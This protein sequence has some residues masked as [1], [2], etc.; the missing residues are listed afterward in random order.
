MSQYADACIVIGRFCNKHKIS[1][2]EATDFT[3]TL[4][5]YALEWDTVDLPIAED[6]KLYGEMEEYLCQP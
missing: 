6:L 1:L 5:G 2:S 3:E 4:L